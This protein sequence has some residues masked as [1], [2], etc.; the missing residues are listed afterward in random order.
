MFFAVYFGLM[1]LAFEP[2]VRRF[3]PT[4]LIS[5]NR[6]LA[7]RFRDPA[8]GRDLLVGATVGVW[9]WPV[10]EFLTVLAPDWLGPAQPFWRL[11]PSTLLGG[12]HLVAMSLFCL[13]SVGVG[14]ALLLVLGLLRMLLQKWWFWA[15]AFVLFGMF[16]FILSD[17]ASLAR[18]LTVAALATSLL[19]LYTRL[20]LM[21]AISFLF[22]SYMLTDFPIT[23]DWDAWYWGSSL[24]ALTV[25]AAVGVFGFC[26]STTGHRLLG[27]RLART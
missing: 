23:A 14:L 16:Y 26:T 7:G 18:W 15:P 2:Y 10:L 12:R 4:L 19:L 1:Y 20:G 11:V 24:Y 3:W 9:F 27:D 6:V 13:T 5:W 17:Y 22:A 25:V 8:V 21:A